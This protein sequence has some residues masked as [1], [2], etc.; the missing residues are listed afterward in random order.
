MLK[1]LDRWVQKQREPLY[2]KTFEEFAQVV[3]AQTESCVRV[4]PVVRVVGVY[5]DREAARDDHTGVVPFVVE[6]HPTG[7]KMVGMYMA[8]TPRGREVVF[9]KSYEALDVSSPYLRENWRML[10]GLATLKEDTQR[11]CAELQAQHPSFLFDIEDHKIVA[12][13][14]MVRRP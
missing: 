4:V 6:F 5:R 8:T 14:R 13:E 12:P 3:G 9:E 1:K 7:W 2:A 10:E 11:M